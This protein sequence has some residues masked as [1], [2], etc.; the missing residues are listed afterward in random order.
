MQ[1]SG[2]RSTGRSARFFRRAGS[3]EEAYAP[4]AAASWADAR[5]ISSERLERRASKLV[6]DWARAE[7]ALTEDRYH[8]L[9]SRGS[10][11]H[12]FRMEVTV[13][14][15]CLGSSATDPKSDD[16]KHPIKQPG[17]RGTTRDFSPRAPS[18]RRGRNRIARVR[19]RV[20]KSSHPVS[21]ERQTGWPNR[22]SAI[23]I[24]RDRD[25]PF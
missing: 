12:V 3:S 25:F 8:W 16:A 7:V 15:H 11:H 20:A 1:C 22:A 5:C 9:P 4:I 10:P 6:L 23:P 21:H 14:C 2:E 17:E 24:H 18:L 13:R 19:R